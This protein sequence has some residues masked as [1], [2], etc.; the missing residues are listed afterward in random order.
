M[1]LQDTW[2]RL[3]SLVAEQIC[4]KQLM[5]LTDESH[6]RIAVCGRQCGKNWTVC[7]LMLLTAMEHDNANI[8]Y[9]NS[10][11]AEARRIMWSD[12]IDGI[13]AVARDLGLK[14][15]ANEAR[16]ELM[17][18]NGSLITLLGADRG[19][20][21]KLRGSKL[22]LL[23]VDEM[24][25]MDDEGL[26]RAIEQI[27]PAA[28]V[29]RKGSF[30]GIGTPEE[31][32]AGI[33]HSICEDNLY[34]QFKTHHWTAEDLRDKR[35]DIW[36]GLLRWKSESGM[37]DDDPRWLREGR[38]LWVRQDDRMMLPLADHNIWDGDYPAMIPS[39][40]GT[41]VRR[42]QEM[43]HFG[44]L[45]L[46][47][48]DGLALGVYSLSREEGVLREVYS[49]KQ[50]Q[51][52]TDQLVSVVAEAMAKYRIKVIFSDNNEQR[53]TDLLRRKGV[54]LVLESKQDKVMWIRDIQAKAR[55][56]RVQIL[57]GSLLHD[58]LKTLTPDPK[59]LKRRRL[60]ARPGAEDH[61]WDTLRYAY[62][63]AFPEGISAPEAPMSDS[64][65]NKQRAD[66]TRRAA[67]APDPS[68][69]TKHEQGHRYR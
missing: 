47:W 40:D 30:V 14:F 41:L 32:C 52:D 21:E 43:Q 68:R 56:G 58:E 62:R 65:M 69:R 61:C 31:F 59:Q 17:F 44:G 55:V 24:Q 45:D 60:E 22:N 28:L 53:T 26:K 10:T 23:V 6:W 27:I 25:K 11:F 39:K 13:P 19:A 38:G 46:G 20:W 33:L 29:A 2:Q 5:F 7:R 18:P 34:P 63:G 16:L 3:V 66:E 9:V 35:S 42:A 51:L 8:I 37:S 50:T 49:F 64:D 12:E 67:L 15:T 57:R 36:D 48:T 1:D 54:P 4:E